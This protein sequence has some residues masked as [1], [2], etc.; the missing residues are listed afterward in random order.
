[1]NAQQTMCG[2]V[3]DSHCHSRAVGNASDFFFEPFRFFRRLGVDP[4]WVI[5][6]LVSSLLAIATIAVATPLI[7]HISIQQLP[8]PISSERQAELLSTISM[9]QYIGAVA[10]PIA[11]LLKLSLSAFVVWS[12]LILIEAEVSF[13]KVLSVLAYACLVPSFDRLAGILLNYAVPVESLD[14]AHKMRSTLLSLSSFLNTTG[15]PLFRTLCDSLSL[16]S[17]WYYF[18]LIVGLSAACSTRRMRSFIVVFI[19]W[20]LQLG[21]NIILYFAG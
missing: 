17:I 1:M 2:R 10:A 8:N 15:H 16:L 9:S 14:S 21:L 5:P 3:A 11:Q 19:L 20:L 6:F 7:T 18:L 12:L 13:R 4:G